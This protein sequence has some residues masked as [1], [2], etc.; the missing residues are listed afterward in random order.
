M[1][2]RHAVVREGVVAGLLGAAGVAI[3]FLI[4]DT[5]GG[6][7][8]YTPSMLGAALLSVFGNP[9]SEGAVTHVIVYTLFHGAAFIAVGLVLAFFVHEAEREPEVLA[10][11][12]IL[13]ILFELGVYIATALL[14]EFNEFGRLAWYQVAVG[15]A[16]ATLAMGTYMWRRHPKLRTELAHAYE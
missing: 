2:E 9:G 1:L 14:A 12:I 8:F 16:I 10:A 4:V 15:N 3:W 7:P 5:I 13:F 6:R 11:L